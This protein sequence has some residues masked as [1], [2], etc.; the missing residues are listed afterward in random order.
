MAFV[1]QS[2]VWE[3]YEAVEF[4]GAWLVTFGFVI[5]TPAKAR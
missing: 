3:I 1:A 4:G 5:V 2:G